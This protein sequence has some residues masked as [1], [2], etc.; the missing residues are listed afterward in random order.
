MMEATPEEETKDAEVRTPNS[1][2]SHS[3]GDGDGDSGSAENEM[4]SMA[5]FTRTFQAGDV[6][7]AE[8]DFG[9]SMYTVLEGTVEI[10]TA[11]SKDPLR[12]FYVG[13]MF[14]ELAL[15]E[16]GIRTATAIALTNV[17][18]VEIDKARFIY[19]VG[20]QPAFALSVMRSLARRMDGRV[21][22]LPASKHEH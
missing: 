2:N 18:A 9:R 10:R 14:G 17:R 11:N 21:S 5:R 6:L 8:G 1:Q 13:D 22:R 7:F 12:T 15:L 19:L 20:Q 3:D 4:R 16:E